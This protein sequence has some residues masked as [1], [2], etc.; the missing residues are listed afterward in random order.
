[1]F[2]ECWEPRRPDEAKELLRIHRTA[3]A[4]ACYPSV[5]TGD[6]PELV[7]RMQ[8]SA[9]RDF[10]TKLEKNVQSK[11]ETDVLRPVP[12]TDQEKVALGS[13]TT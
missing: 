2:S 5:Q 4:A 6:N 3:M 9:L 8:I 13:L 7:G 12:L 1:L 10:A 11:K